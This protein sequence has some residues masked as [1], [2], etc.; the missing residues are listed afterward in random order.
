M[1][2]FLGVVLWIEKPLGAFVGEVLYA[3]SVRF[4]PQCL[5]FIAFRLIFSAQ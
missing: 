4:E 3:D 1:P 5:H 2:L